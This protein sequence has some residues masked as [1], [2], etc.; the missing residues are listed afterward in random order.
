MYLFDEDKES[1]DG[2]TFYLYA[3]Y[4]SFTKIKNIT[5]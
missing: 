1:M 3:E 4:K 2:Y 5:E